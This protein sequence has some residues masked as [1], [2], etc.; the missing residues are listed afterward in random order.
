MM[1]Q[2]VPLQKCV[3]EG[4]GKNV[5]RVLRKNDCDPIILY[6]FKLLFLHKNKRQIFLGVQKLRKDTIN[7]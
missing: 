6:L 4:S 1:H 3:L 2:I 7:I 5:Y